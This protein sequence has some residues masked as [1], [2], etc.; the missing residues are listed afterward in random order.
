MRRKCTKQ[1]KEPSNSI[2]YYDVRVTGLNKFQKIYYDVLA[3]MKRDIPEPKPYP[4]LSKSSSKIT[5]TPAHINCMMMMAILRRP[6][7]EGGP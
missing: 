6:R 5:M 3:T 1:T 7:V 2:P 4:D